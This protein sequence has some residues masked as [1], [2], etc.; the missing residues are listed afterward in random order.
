M[1]LLVRWQRPQGTLC[2]LDLYLT[3]VFVWPILWLCGFS[4]FSVSFLV[5]QNGTTQCDSNRFY[6]CW[7]SDVRQIVGAVIP[8]DK[9]PMFLVFWYDCH[10]ARSRADG[11]SQQ[12]RNC[13]YCWFFKTNTCR[14]QCRSS[15]EEK[16][17]PLQPTCWGQTQQQCYYSPLPQPQS[18]AVQFLLFNFYNMAK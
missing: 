18:R 16:P 11:I 10:T 3:L 15:L 2:H 1:V 14:R 5:E 8:K 13:I 6:S 7:N 9:K 17:L 12:I 4:S